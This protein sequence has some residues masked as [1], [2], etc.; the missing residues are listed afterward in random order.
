MSSLNIPLICRNVK[1]K[2]ATVT[3]LLYLPFFIRESKINN[4]LERLL[5]GLDKKGT[6]LF[7]QWGVKTV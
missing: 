3:F 4:T 5:A 2:D 7:F 6:E 1:T